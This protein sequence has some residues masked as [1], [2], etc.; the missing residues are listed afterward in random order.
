MRTVIIAAGLLLFEPAVDAAQMD[1]GTFNNL[2]R[3]MHEAEVLARAGEPDRVTA[4]GHTVAYGWHGA[5]GLHAAERYAF[6][7]VP[8]PHE[9]DPWL[10]VVVLTHGR[11]SALERR[12]I[13]G[14]PPAAASA[15]GA[16]VSG[17]PARDDDV[18][19]ARAERTLRAAERYAEVRWRLRE[20]AH[21][22]GAGGEAQ[23]RRVYRG[24]DEHGTPYFGDVAPAGA[25]RSPG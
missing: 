9:H 18:R 11:V 13:M 6:H 2:R 3:G 19:R 14:R 24:T 7:Y 15:A 21:G 12:K 22:D 1:I 10:T 5:R 23:A 25:T 8:E 17:A 16:A 4:Y 20:R